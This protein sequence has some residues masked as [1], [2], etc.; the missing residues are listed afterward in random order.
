M[1]HCA[2]VHVSRLW[3]ELQFGELV[4]GPVFGGVGGID[5]GSFGHVLSVLC[6][7]DL[8]RSRI[9]TSHITDQ[10]VLLSEVHIVSGVDDRTG[11]RTCREVRVE[12]N[13]TL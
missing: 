1:F 8:Y 5:A 2:A 7:G 13:D 11:G 10:D 9:E 6:P 12:D 4:E 3:D